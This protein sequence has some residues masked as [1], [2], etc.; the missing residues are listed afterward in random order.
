MVNRESRVW[1]D[2]GVEPAA[3][4]EVYVGQERPIAQYDNWAMWTVTTDIKTLFDVIGTLEGVDGV[5]E[6]TY[7]TKANRGDAGQEGHLYIEHDTGIA[8][9]DN[10]TEWIELGA[11]DYGDL[12]NRT[13]G[14]G[15]HDDTVAAASELT[16]LPVYGDASD[17]TITRTYNT[18][19]NG[20]LLPDKY[21]VEEGVTMSVTNGVLAIYA[22][23]EIVVNG[24]IDASGYGAPG[25]AGATNYGS[26]N[27]GGAGTDANISFNSDSSG[28]NPNEI[29]GIEDGTSGSGTGAG[30]GG[31]CESDQSIIRGNDGGDTA[32]SAN[33]DDTVL[34]SAPLFMSPLQKQTLDLTIYG[35]ISGAGGGAGGAKD[36]QEGAHASPG[37]DGGD[38]GGVVLLV[39]PT[40][41]G[42][43]EIRCEGGDGQ[44]GTDGADIAKDG[45]NGAWGGAGGGG[46]GNGGGIF[47]LTE[48]FEATFSYSVA[49]GTGGAGGTGYSQGGSSYE[50]ADGGSGG[51]GYAG[52]VWEVGLGD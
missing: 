5:T 4:D 30:G 34:D 40:I 50:G 32:G 27:E 1:S 33:D 38:G 6:I 28:I 24:V 7:D 10:G 41:R 12:S 22:T 37:G 9:V 8:L 11:S 3:G 19:E 39:A 25:G 13:H 44:D 17:G 29:F 16:T 52:R 48:D 2:S 18:N 47:I 49:G 36:E 14:M 35:G 21:T 15:D 23:D 31:D 43:G 46:A 51:D 42:S 26:N 45:V 20:I